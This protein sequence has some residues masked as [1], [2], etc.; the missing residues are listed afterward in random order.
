M[1]RYTS[2]VSTKVISLALISLFL[3]STDLCTT[4]RTLITFIKTRVLEMMFLFVKK[5]LIAKI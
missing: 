5:V 4:H 2:N 1:Y 3:Q